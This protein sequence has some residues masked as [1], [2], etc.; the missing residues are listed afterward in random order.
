MLVSTF[1][2]ILYFDVGV[3]FGFLATDSLMGGL[4]G[5]IFGPGFGIAFWLLKNKHIG[6]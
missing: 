2:L 4:F 3:A 6:D 1:I 5:V